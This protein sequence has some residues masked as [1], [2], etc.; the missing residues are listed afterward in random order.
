MVC[1]RLLMSKEYC[2]YT[3]RIVLSAQ[4]R[5]FGEAT[6]TIEATGEREAWQSCRISRIVIEFK[7]GIFFP[8]RVEIPRKALED[9]GPV[10]M[11]RWEFRDEGPAR[12][13]SKFL[14][15]VGYA[16]HQMD[17]DNWQDKTLHF[18]IEDSTFK[19]LSIMT[20]LGADSW[21]H[22]RFDY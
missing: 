4:T 21:D 13:E 19:Y 9:A 16:P 6:A 8:A 12:T 22:S 10:Y 7:N 18:V 17:E 2:C 11:N 20:P 14:Y 3:N 15:L 1:D 5:F